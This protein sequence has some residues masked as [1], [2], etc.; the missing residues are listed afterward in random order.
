MKKLITAIAIAL[1]FACGQSTKDE[2][3]E[4]IMAGIFDHVEYYANPTQSIMV[5][6]FTDGRAERIG[7]NENSECFYAGRDLIT[8]DSIRI[9]G[10]PDETMKDNYSHKIIISKRDSARWCVSVGKIN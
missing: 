8:G 7:M 10:I 3:R 6:Y 4:L 9:L 5:I 1:I 2:G